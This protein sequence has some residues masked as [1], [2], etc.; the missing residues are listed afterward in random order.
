[1]LEIAFRT[2][3]NARNICEPTKVENLVVHDLYH[4]E[5]VSG[6]DRID[7]YIAMYTNYM[8]WVDGG[9][10]ILNFG[11]IRSALN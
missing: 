5:R 1:M 3:N 6:G 7:Q 8:L 10:F 9:I 4:V 11:A 2:N